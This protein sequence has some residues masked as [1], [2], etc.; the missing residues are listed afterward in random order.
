MA[1]PLLVV[2][3]LNLKEPGVLP[4]QLQQGLVGALLHNLPLVQQQDAVA[5][6]GGGKAVGDVEGGAALG[7]LA[8]A[9]VQLVLGDGVQGRAVGSSK[10]MMGPFLYRAR[11]SISRWSSP[12][13]S[14]MPSS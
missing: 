12:P 7:Q 4:A 10:M 6:P 2:L 13:E 11:A 14:W 5:E 9:Q 8:V 1:V 3:A